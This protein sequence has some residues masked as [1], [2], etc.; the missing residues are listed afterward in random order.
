MKRMVA[1]ILSQYGSTA[2]LIRDGTDTTVTGIF[3]PVQ[4]KGWQ[5]YTKELTPLG[6]AE[7]GQYLFIASGDE[8][9]QE[10]DCLEIG[11]RQYLLRRTAQ[12]Y[13]GEEAIYSWALCV[14]KGGEDSWGS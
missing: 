13:Y 12:W 9:L 3:Q 10:G 8:L 5:N 11:E 1:G 4:A 2:R 7:K 14:E 6:L